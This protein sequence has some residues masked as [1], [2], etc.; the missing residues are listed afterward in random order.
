MPLFSKISP[1]A[2]AYWISLVHLNLG[3]LINRPLNAL[4]SNG[5]TRLADIDASKD[6]STDDVIRCIGEL[7]KSETAFS[8]KW[9]PV[10]NLQVMLQNRIKEQL[11]V[12]NILKHHWRN[13]LTHERWR[14]MVS[15]NLRP[16]VQGVMDF[17]TPYCETDNELSKWV[18]SHMGLL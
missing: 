8:H 2:E 13:F 18:T 9:L 4:G 7:T 14:D 16:R 17:L 5:L 15:G 11:S 10:L 6:Y 3:V 1:K 12:G